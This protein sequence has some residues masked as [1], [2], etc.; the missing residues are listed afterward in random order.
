[1]HN[2]QTL[3]D[4][5]PTTDARTAA[6]YEMGEL[7]GTGGMSE[8]RLARQPMLNR[9]VAVKSATSPVGE[10]ALLNEARVTARL[11]HSG[12][13]PV[14]DLGHDEQGRM[15]LFMRRIEGRTWRSYVAA[16]GALSAPE[17]WTGEPL[18]WHLDVLCRVARVVEHAHAEGIVHRDI[19]PGNVMI[20]TDGQVWLMDWGLASICHRSEERRVGKECRSRWSPYH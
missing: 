6:R 17:A 2:D 16:D 13:V 20:G 9:W 15:A 18:S 1:M 8:V 14:I 11:N 7:L 10:E 19:K 3:V 12:I 4:F 5:P